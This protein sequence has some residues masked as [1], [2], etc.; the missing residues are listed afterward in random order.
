MKELA[1]Q[2]CSYILR[3]RAELTCW[4]WWMHGRVIFC[5]TLQLL[6]WKLYFTLMYRHKVRDFQR[7]I[8]Q[9]IAD[10]AL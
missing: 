8:S 10:R 2:S 4:D 5:L 3:P 9:S 1:V 6:Y 7:L